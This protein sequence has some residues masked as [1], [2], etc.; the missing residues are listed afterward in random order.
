MANDMAESQFKHAVALVEAAISSLGIDPTSAKQP[1]SPGRVSY[2]LR[3]GSARIAISVFHG[4]E[5]REGTL[6]V[7]APVVKTPTGEGRLGLFTRLLELNVRELVGAAFGI[8]GDDVLVVSERA[9]KDLDASEVDAAIRSVG[10]L[11]DVYDDQL[12]SAFGTV[13]SS[14][15]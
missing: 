5:D 9:L 6:R 3:R 15:A 12:A 4:T 7:G 10:R 1:E 2:A 8:A 13:R 14:G 11:A